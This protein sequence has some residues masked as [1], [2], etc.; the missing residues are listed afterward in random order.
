MQHYMYRKDIMDIR[1]DTRLDIHFAISP[2]AQSATL[3]SIR[4][5]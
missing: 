5:K 4:H 3:S 2:P 1:L